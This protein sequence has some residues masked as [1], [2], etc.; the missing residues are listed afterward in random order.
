MGWGSGSVFPSGEQVLGMEKG[1]GVFR[2][3]TLLLTLPEPGGDLCYYL[4]P[5]SDL[6]QGNHTSLRISIFICKRI[7][8][9]RRVVVRMEENNSRKTYAAGPGIC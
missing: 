9:T 5:L 4:L 2:M 8:P 1:L 6:G 7:Q 3:V